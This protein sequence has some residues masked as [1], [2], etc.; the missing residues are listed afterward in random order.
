MSLLKENALE[1]LRVVFSESEYRKTLKTNLTFSK[2]SE[3][4]RIPDLKIEDIKYAVEYL[5]DLGYITYGNQPILHDIC[6]TAKGI[7]YYNES[8]L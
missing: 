5:S 6:I 4:V 8:F 2:I 3:E 1:V 7:D